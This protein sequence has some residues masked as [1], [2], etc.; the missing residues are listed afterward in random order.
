[1]TPR[2]QRRLQ[3]KLA[4]KAEK[5]ARLHQAS[6]AVATA[7]LLV[8]QAAS[9]EQQTDLT[10]PH[11]APDPISPAKL[12]ANLANAQL[13]TGPLTAEGK[14]VVSQN[15]TK[16]GLTGKFKVLPSES[17]SH[18]D[19]LL[20]GLLEAEAPVGDAEVEMVH[21]MAEALWLSRRSMR[22][23]DSCFPA[24]LSGTPAEQRAA[25]KSLSLY[26]RYQATHDRVYARCAKE[27]RMRR[28][29]RARLE[30]G[31]VSQTLKQA[32]EGRRQELHE[33]RQR[34]Q[35]TREQLQLGRI[36]MAIAK[37]EALE[38]KNSA[39]KAQL[40]SK[41]AESALVAAA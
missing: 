22:L 28:N 16:H 32:A 6:A 19:R 17:Q 37:A 10:H 35:N 26:M 41:T 7:T 9:S 11:S 31:F 39:R 3:E 13:S 21:Q 36:R 40:T 30:R 27:L 12:A 15:A 25:E 34:L 33:A 4:R 14:A 29:E 1:M 8:A 5:R 38:L 23:Q 2:Q 24:L 18:F 20:A